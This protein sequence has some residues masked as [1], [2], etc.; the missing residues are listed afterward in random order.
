VFERDKFRRLV[1]YIAFKTS[2]YPG[3]GA[4][5]LNKVL[6]FADTRLYATRRKPITGAT[7]IREKYGP[8]P[9]QIMPVKSEL[10]HEGRVK[11]TRERFHNQNITRLTAAAPPDM[12]VFTSEE[13]KAVDYWI[14][15]IAEDHTATSISDLTHDISWEIAAMGEELPYHA[16]FATRA[17]RPKGKELEWATA[18]VRRRDS[19]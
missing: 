5:K 2:R 14:K 15:H 10:I 1:Q 16:I 7:Y 8:V 13:V 4:T 11:E 18:Q 12:S 6:W 19:R 17:R 9:R 3:F